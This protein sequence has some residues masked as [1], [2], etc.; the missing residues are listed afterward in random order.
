MDSSDGAKAGPVLGVAAGQSELDELVAEAVLS[1]E[2]VR[3]DA[4]RF[5]DAGGRVG[6]ITMYRINA[7]V[8]TAQDAHEAAASLEEDATFFAEKA[9]DLAKRATVGLNEDRWQYPAAAAR[10]SAAVAQEAKEKFQ[11]AKESAAGA[12]DEDAEV[13]R[14][15]IEAK[16][17][18]KAAKKWRR[19]S[20]EERH[21]SEIRHLEEVAK[22]GRGVG[23]C[24]V[25][26]A[27]VI[28]LVL[29]FVV[30]P[31]GGFAACGAV[32]VEIV[33]ALAGR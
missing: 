32:L 31:L 25:V 1:V 6:V 27:V 8:R 18:K 29:F 13:I 19:A 24:G 20:S 16:Q 9:I 23:F 17:A 2:A 21:R 30:L 11:A 33:E 15:R 4:E 5:K 12:V 3:R 10:E 28:A 22:E 14:A 7:A 26:S